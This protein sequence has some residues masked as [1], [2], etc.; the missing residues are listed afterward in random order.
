[1]START[2]ALL[3]VIQAEGALKRAAELAP[4]LTRPVLLAA[5]RDAQRA[6]SAVT[7]DLPLRTRRAA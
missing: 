2:K 7:H 4:Q 1:M 5:L 3:L 6:R